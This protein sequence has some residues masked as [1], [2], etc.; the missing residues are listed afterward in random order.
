MYIYPDNLKSKATLWFWELKDVAIIGIALVISVTTFS[1]LGIILPL[2]V[3]ASY[4][5]LT[6]RFDDTT[7][8]KFICNAY[9][10]FIGVR[11]LYEW[12]VG[13]E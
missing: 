6:I 2:V 7:I 12:S 9:N 3:T 5:F 11:Q 10:Y 4:G 1:K 13:D 8:L